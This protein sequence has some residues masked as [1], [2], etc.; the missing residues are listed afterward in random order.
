MSRDLEKIASDW[1]AFA[2]YGASEAPDRIHAA[3][4]VLYDLV[5]DA[6]A[7]AWDVI[8]IVVRRHTLGDLYSFAKT[9]AQDIVGLTAAGP[10]EDL[11]SSCGHDYIDA[12]EQEAHRDQRMAWTLGGVW[13]STTPDEVWYRVQLVADNSYWERPMRNGS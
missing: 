1:I 8:Q 4:W 10:L 3:G 12:I 2:R 11:I 9:E 5:E 13:Q 6:P 7:T